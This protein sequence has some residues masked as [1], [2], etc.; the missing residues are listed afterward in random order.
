MRYFFAI[1]AFVA[2][3]AASTAS[4]ANGR[5]PYANQLVEQPGHPEVILARTT[6]GLLVSRDRGAS[7]NWICEQIIGFTNGSDPSLALFSD[8]SMAVAGFFGLAIS[9]D[10]A[11]S[12]PF[13]PGGLE[14][15]YVIDIVLDKQTPSRGLAI[16][17]T[18]A[19]G[20][21]KYSQLFE[22]TDNG[23]TWP[24]IGPQL[25]PNL[26]VTT[27]EAA[28]S[29]PQRLY[30]SGGL[31][32]AA[33]RH[34][35]VQSSEDRGLTWSS[36]VLIDTPSAYLSAV[37]PNDPDRVYVRAFNPFGDTLLVS[38]DGAKSFTKVITITGAMLGFA[39]SPDGSKVA[40]A[41][42]S[43]G[44]MVAVTHA[45]G[46]TPDGGTDA[47]V[48]AGS[49]GGAAIVFEQRSKVP[50]TCLTWTAETLYGCGNPLEKS[51]FV[52]AKSSDEGAT[53]SDA[54]LPGLCDII[55][56]QTTCGPTAPAAV[57][58]SDPNP[59]PLVYDWPTQR[60]TFKCEGGAGGD[61]AA[62]AGTQPPV[63][64]S[65]CFCHVPTA[66][67]GSVGTAGL[68]ICGLLGA[69]A[70]ARGARRRSRRT[71]PKE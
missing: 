64:A 20:G 27:I 33:G 70:M 5:F 31:I 4:S 46:P 19:P 14:K 54:V 56:P 26:I 29:R 35:F 63:L 55:G 48:D 57:C 59:L 16:T 50:V 2:A 69:A 6:F 3:T 47:G 25:D 21:T 38:T 10:K 34:G 65:D 43:I 13:V 11:C 45:A 60:K 62:D 18:A 66:G 24:A 28:P 30:L 36:K 23:A 12:F 51:P 9:H 44:T 7:W 52:I 39:L 68:C 53:W 22:T 15:Q 1:G 41:G 42:P 61:A 71:S 67:G 8:G 49:D 37:D 32:D 17:A 58:I 40:I